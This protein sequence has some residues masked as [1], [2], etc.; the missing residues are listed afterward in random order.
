MRTGG[1]QR[2]R[3]AVRTLL[4]HFSPH[5]APQT[6]YC[7]CMSVQTVSLHVAMWARGHAATH[8]ALRG[9]ASA[10]HAPRRSYR[11]VSVLYR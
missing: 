5:C 4:A 8:W 10:V 7:L 2:Y 9:A 1:L 6:G 11:V 3:C